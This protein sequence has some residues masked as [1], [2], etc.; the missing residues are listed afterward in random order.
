MCVSVGNNGHSTKYIVNGIKEVY[1]G[2]FEADIVPSEN[3]RV[4]SGRVLELL[5]RQARSAKDLAE[6]TRVVSELSRNGNGSHG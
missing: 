2:V 3:G 6:L 4:I 5:F 1:P